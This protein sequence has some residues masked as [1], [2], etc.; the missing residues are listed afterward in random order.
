MPCGQDLTLGGHVTNIA[1]VAT[2]STESLH[3]VVIEV[4]CASSCV[5]HI[6]AWR[7]VCVSMTQLGLPSPRD[8]IITTLSGKR[9][10]IDEEM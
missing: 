10:Q 1:G 2:L 6:N 5:S 8:L 4:T 7:V 9:Q 3:S